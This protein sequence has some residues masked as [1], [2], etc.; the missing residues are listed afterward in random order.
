ML[1]QI[2]MNEKTRDSRLNKNFTRLISLNL[3]SDALKFSFTFIR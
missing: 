1:L 2:F 3:R